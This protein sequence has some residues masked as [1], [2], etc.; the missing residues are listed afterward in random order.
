MLMDEL[1]GH[2]SFPDGRRTSLGRARPDVAGGEDAR[3]ARLEQ[4][5]RARRNAGEHE[6]L[7]VARDDVAEPFGAG[8]RAEE[9]EEI[10]EAELL[11]VAHRHAVELAVDSVQLGD[12]AAVAD[13]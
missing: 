4:G 7:L 6:A 9:E 8:E 2:R 1:H 10:R 5:V 12:L 3:H 13:G 11:A